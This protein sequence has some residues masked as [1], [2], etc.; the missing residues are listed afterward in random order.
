MF[1]DVIQ[2]VQAGLQSLSIR[3]TGMTASRRKEGVLLS[4]E[5]FPRVSVR[6]LAI[7]RGT[8]SDRLGLF[9]DS[10]A[11]IEEFVN[12]DMAVQPRYGLL[13]ARSGHILPHLLT[14]S[15]VQSP[16]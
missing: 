15:M 6:K 7:N 16:S 1:V 13:P 4:S 10:T 11:E 14:Y 5:I 8:Q 12:Q 9:I 3:N 2:E